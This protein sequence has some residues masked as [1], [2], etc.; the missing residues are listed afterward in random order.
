MPGGPFGCILPTTNQVTRV[1]TALHNSG[2]SY[3]EVCEIMM[4]FYKPVWDRLRPT[5]RM[6][7][8]TGYLVFARSIG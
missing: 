2:F 6:V 4:R 5:D 1:L 8:H 3:V 7:A